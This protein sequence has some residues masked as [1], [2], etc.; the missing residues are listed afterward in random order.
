M[1]LTQSEED[2]NC[3]WKGNN[4]KVFKYTTRNEYRAYVWH[5]DVEL[6]WVNPKEVKLTY[7]PEYGKIFVN[8]ILVETVSPKSYDFAAVKAEIKHGLL[9]IE[10]PPKKSVRIEIP[11]IVG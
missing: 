5:V 2:L 4:M 6:P 7:C 3:P 10:V 11:L 1:G 9:S 8:D